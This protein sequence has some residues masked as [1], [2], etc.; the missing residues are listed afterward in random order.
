MIFNLNKKVTP[1]SF[2]PGP[3]NLQHTVHF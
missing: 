1:S 2:E 3:Q